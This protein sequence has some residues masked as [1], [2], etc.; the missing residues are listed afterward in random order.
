MGDDVG[1]LG[2]EA[3]LVPDRDGDVVRVSDGVPDG[4]RDTVAV[5]EATVTRMMWLFS[6]AI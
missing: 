4:V 5:A 2:G 3:P 6:S 1:V